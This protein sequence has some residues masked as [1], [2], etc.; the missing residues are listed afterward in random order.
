[1]EIYK[2]LVEFTKWLAMWY[3]IAMLFNYVAINLFGFGIDDSD[4]DKNHRSGVKVITDYK[5]GLQYLES[6][7]GGITPRLDANGKQVRITND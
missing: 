3:L 1:M 2:G 7:R 6:G 4:K 5:T